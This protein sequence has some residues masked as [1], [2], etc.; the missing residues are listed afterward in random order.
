MRTAW[1]SAT[2]ATL[3]HFPCIHAGSVNPVVRYNAASEWLKSIEKPRFPQFSL[4]FLLFLPVFSRF[5]PSDPPA[6]LA[7]PAD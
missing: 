2:Q 6:R 4:G 7:L 3:A 1:G 5:F